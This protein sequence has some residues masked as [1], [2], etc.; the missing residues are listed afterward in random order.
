MLFRCWSDYTFITDRLSI[1]MASI[2]SVS[3]FF[4]FA[5]HQVKI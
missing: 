5:F 2:A 3:E 4:L 1:F